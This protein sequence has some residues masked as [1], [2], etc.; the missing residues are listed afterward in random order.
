MPFTKKKRPKMKL[1]EMRQF[2]IDNPGFFK[3]SKSFMAN[4][5]NTTEAVVTRVLNTLKEEKKQYYS[6]FLM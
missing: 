4:R 6:Q 1:V 3:K 5:L 2:F